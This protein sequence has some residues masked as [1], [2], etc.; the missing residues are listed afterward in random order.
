MK[1]KKKL[2]YDKQHKYFGNKSW[3]NIVEIYSLYR[4]FFDGHVPVIG[5]RSIVRQF[6]GVLCVATVQ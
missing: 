5:D 4:L 1:I 3:I 2:T 6:A